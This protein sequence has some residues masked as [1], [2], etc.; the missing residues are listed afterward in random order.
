M[1]VTA[2]ISAIIVGLIVDALGQFVL[3]GKQNVPI[4]LTIVVGMVAAPIGTAGLGG[5]GVADTAGVDW[6]E[7]LI[8]VVLAAVG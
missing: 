3:P 4:R 2:I 8:Q 1:T 5:M 7:I 6:V